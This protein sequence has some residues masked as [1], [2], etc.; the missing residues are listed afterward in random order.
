[1]YW[2]YKVHT[3]SIGGLFSTG[4]VNPVQFQLLL[5]RYGLQGWELVN[6]FDTSDARGG[7]RL[8]VLTFKRP[9]SEEAAAAPPAV[10]IR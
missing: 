2:E 10:P 3:E 4:Q 5:N 6:A 7:S 9:L 8:L 1:M